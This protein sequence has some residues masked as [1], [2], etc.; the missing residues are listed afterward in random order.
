[1]KPLDYSIEWRLITAGKA[2]LEW[3]ASPSEGPDAGDVKLHVESAGLVFAALS[4]E[5]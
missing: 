1:M 4:R 2:H 5:R 3:S